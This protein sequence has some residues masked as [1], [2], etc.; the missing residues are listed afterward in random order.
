MKKYN[1][2]QRGGSLN[3]SYGAAESEEARLNRAFGEKFSSID[4][5][6]DLE[7]SDY[8]IKNSTQLGVLVVGDYRISLSLGEMDRIMRTLEDTL[9]TV[10]MKGRLGVF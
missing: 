2:N 9:T 6:F 4:F 3:H 10:N 1:P 8:P 5:E 7:E